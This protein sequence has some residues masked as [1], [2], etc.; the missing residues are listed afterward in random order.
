MFDVHSITYTHVM[1]Q[2]CDPRDKNVQT[3]CARKCKTAFTVP[4]GKFCATGTKYRKKYLYQSVE[5]LEA[6]SLVEA[7]SPI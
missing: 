4:G 5:K 2:V 1:A 3:Q 6:Q 7:Q